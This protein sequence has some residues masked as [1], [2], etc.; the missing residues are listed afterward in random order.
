MPRL[1]VNQDETINKDSVGKE[2]LS[3]NKFNGVC[4]VG[5]PDSTRILQYPYPKC[6]HSNSAS[7]QNIMHDV[8]FFNAG[9]AGVEAAIFVG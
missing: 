4:T 7:A 9:E 5:W 2:Q 1:S 3:K 6:I 8:G